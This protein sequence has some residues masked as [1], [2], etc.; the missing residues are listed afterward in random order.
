MSPDSPYRGALPTLRQLQF[1]MALQSEGA[2]V[3]A[4]ELIG[5]TQPTLSAG[6]KELEAILGVRLV[7]RGAAGAELTP[8]GK[9]AAERAHRALAEVEELVAALRGGGEPLAGPFRL[10]AIPT[11]APFLLPHLVPALRVS[12]PRLRLYLREDL[13]ARLMDGLRART[14]DAALIALP[15]DAPGVET[16]AIFEDE[17][18]LAAP[19]GHRLA[20]QPEV[21]PEDLEGEAVLLL[22]DGHCLRDHALSVCRLS[23]KRSVAELG[24]TS[25]PTLAHMAAGGIGVTLLPRLAVEGGAAAGADLVVRPFKTPLVGR[26]VGV[27][28]RAKG[29]R[30]REAKLIAEAVRR[31]ASPAG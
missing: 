29:P 25:L 26:A 19:R 1:L 13:T 4:A 3:R 16:E 28:W 18:L 21:V 10:G 14:L 30:G 27:A 8:E 12:H 23:P 9:E 31:L 20:E 5:V 11:I 17:F 2:F 24:A 7:E 6:I 22:E 15:Y